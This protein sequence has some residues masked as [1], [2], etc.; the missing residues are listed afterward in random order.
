MRARILLC[1]ALAL[2]PLDRAAA[3]PRVTVT[4]IGEGAYRAMVRGKG[5]V[6]D[7]AQYAVEKQAALLCAR[8]KVEAGGYRYG[9]ET[10]LNNATSN[11][12]VLTYTQDF[13]CVDKLASNAAIKAPHDDKAVL[14]FT[15]RFLA[16]RDGNDF[17]GALAMFDADT[18]RMADGWSADAA[19]FNEEAGTS[20]GRRIV[21][22]TWYDNPAAVAR[23][24][25][26]ASV[27]Y[28]GG[29]S[30]VP[31]DCGYLLWR[32][33]DG[34]K[35]ELVHEEHKFIPAGTIA[36]LSPAE[37]EAMKKKIGCAA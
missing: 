4:P 14:A 27:D 9:Q 2:I 22:I 6:L 29:Y 31:Q 15:D 25:V 10:A 21:G 35:F 11:Q 23:P 34:Q 16:A 24:G 8:K 20:H 37:V 33:T 5:V 7:E 32:T 36:K 19:R 1:A 30:N 17:D 18:R 3:D 12:G 28:V 26:Y 13:R